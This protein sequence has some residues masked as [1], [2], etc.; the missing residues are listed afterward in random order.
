MPGKESDRSRTHPRHRK[1]GNSAIQPLPIHQRLFK[2]ASFEDWITNHHTLPQRD[3][4][5]LRSLCQSE[6]DPMTRDSRD[7]EALNEIPVGLVHQSSGRETRHA[8]SA[9]LHSLRTASCHV[10][11]PTSF[12]PSLRASF[13]QPDASSHKQWT[14]TTWLVQDS[15]LLLS[16]R[17]VE[18]GDFRWLIESLGLSSK[19]CLTSSS[20]PV[21]RA[22]PRIFLSDEKPC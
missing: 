20:T 5:L 8:K 18:E 2:S 21:G 16:W 7:R 6:G 17:L 1:H 11:P 19:C 9:V 14:T 12:T 10:L 3:G 15:L 4:L 22:V 13:S